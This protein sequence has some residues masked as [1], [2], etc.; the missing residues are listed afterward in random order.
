V[1]TFFQKYQTEDQNFAPKVE[2][3][4]TI[5]SPEAF[6]NLHAMAL[7]VKEIAAALTTGLIGG[8]KPQRVT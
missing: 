8:F 2:N 3:L 1:K 5:L 4:L 7:K 6:K